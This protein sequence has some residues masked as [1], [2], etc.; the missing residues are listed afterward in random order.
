VWLLPNNRDATLKGVRAVGVDIGGEIRENKVWKHLHASF[1]LGNGCNLPFKKETFDVVV[2]CGVLDH[3]YNQ[4]RFLRECRRVLKNNGL[5]LC[6][7]LPNKTGPESLF[8]KVLRTE[9][10]FF[11]RGEIQRLFRECGY[12]VFKV[13]R[14]HVIPEPRFSRAQ[15]IWNRLHKILALLDDALTKTPLRFLGDNWRVYA[16]KK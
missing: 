16:R 13:S 5:F 6:Y 7:Y 1:I 10:Q 15:E 3:V 9:H 12:D 2:C 14:E 8:A 11:E 4:R